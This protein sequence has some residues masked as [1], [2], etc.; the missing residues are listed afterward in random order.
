M[1]LI[2]RNLNLISVQTYLSFP[3]EFIGDY[4]FLSRL[5]GFHLTKKNT[6]S[7]NCTCRLNQRVERNLGLLITKTHAK[8]QVKGSPLFPFFRRHVLEYLSRSFILFLELFFVHHFSERLTPYIMPIFE[9]STLDD[10]LNTI[11]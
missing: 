4:F 1:I 8:E 7:K 10:C 9:S 3:L 5:R 6:F 2:I 11:L